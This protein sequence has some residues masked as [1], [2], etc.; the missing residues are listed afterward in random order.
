MHDV[1]RLTGL[2]RRV[3]WTSTAPPA[4]VI[5]AVQT[6]AA[7]L[8][9]VTVPAAAAALEP[10][11]A[12]PPAA[13]PPLAAPAPPAPPMP[14]SLVSAISGPAP[15]GVSAANERRMPRRAPRYSRQAPQS[16]MCRRARP[17]ALTPRS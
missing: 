9:A 6:T 15:A 10:A 13:A 5:A 1:A 8:H 7:T 16:R 17:E 11:A 4:A 3:A 12:A 2:A 14:S